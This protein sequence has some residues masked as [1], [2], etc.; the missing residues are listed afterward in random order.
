ML[1]QFSVS[2][3]QSISIYNS[4]FFII[5][6]L[7]KSMQIILCYAK[8]TLSIIKVVTFSQIWHPHKR[9]KNAEATKYCVASILLSTSMKWSHLYI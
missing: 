5:L 2:T 8:C 7:P 4:Y 3:M 1:V 6:K 9:K